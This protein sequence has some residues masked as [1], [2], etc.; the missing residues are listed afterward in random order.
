MIKPMSINNKFIQLNV[1]RILSIVFFCS[2]AA[3]KTVQ[4]AATNQ[5]DI[6][7]IKAVSQTVS[8]KISTDNLSGSDSSTG[9]LNGNGSG[10]LVFVIYDPSGNSPRKK[11][12]LI[13][14]SYIDENEVFNDLTLN[15]V[16]KI[17]KTITITNQDLSEF[18]NKSKEPEKL[19]WQI[20]AIAN[21]FNTTEI[22]SI[23]NFINYGILISTKTR[24]KK[25]LTFQE[26]NQT[27][28]LHSN[29]IN[30]N[31]RYD[32]EPNGSLIS[33]T[34]EPSAFDPQLHSY[35]GQ[36]II[37]TAGISEKMKLSIQRIINTDSAE[38][39]KTSYQILGKVKLKH[40][41]NKQDWQ[42][43]FYPY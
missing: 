40:I 32:I 8:T 10:D 17:K 11:S 5:Q 42:I 1:Q 25:A 29:L 7:S 16:L 9:K 35:A 27:R 23:P 18:I 41:K 26:I 24:L 34:G 33:F 20:F 15:D 3:C 21:H 22:L 14:L 6:E 19:Q 12:L 28:A 36:N 37:S 39:L 31:N 4:M 2:I 38:Q 43:I 13:D 30:E